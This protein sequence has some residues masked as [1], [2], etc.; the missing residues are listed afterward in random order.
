MWI[1][2]QGIRAKHP[3]IQGI[4]GGDFLMQT[5]MAHEKDTLSAMRI[6]SDE[7]MANFRLAWQQSKG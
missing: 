7:W 6:I 3:E 2:I 1:A 5:H 4:I